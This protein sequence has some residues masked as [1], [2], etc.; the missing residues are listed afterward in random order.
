MGF[1]MFVTRKEQELFHNRKENLFVCLSN[2]SAICF[3]DKFCLLTQILDA[4]PSLPLSVQMSVLLSLR[5]LQT[6]VEGAMA[7][8]D[9]EGDSEGYLLE[10]GVKE[11]I[12][13]VKANVL[14]LLKFGQVDPSAAEESPVAA[15][16]EKAADTEKAASPPAS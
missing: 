14:N 13:D 10:K 16:V 12:E 3:G 1:L 9:P 8:E 2:H 4:A 6:A 7:L 15:D 11:T 5:Y